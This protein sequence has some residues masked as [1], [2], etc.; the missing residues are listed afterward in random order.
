MNL[1]PDITTLV[2]ERTRV[3]HLL[4]KGISANDILGHTLPENRPMVARLLVQQGELLRNEFR[5][6]DEAE[7]FWAHVGEDERTECSNLGEYGMAQVP[8]PGE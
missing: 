5:S 8:D 2:R 7:A 6:E 3:T 4:D 1:S